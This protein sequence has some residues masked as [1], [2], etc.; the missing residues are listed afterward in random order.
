MYQRRCSTLS[1]GVLS[2]CAEKQRCV[3]LSSWESE[4]V[5][6]TIACTPSLGIQ[7]GL[8]ELGSK[9]VL[10]VASDSKCVIDHSRLRGHSVASKH[11][12]FR[13]LWL[14]EAFVDKKLA[15]EKVHTAER[16]C[17]TIIL[18]LPC[19]RIPVSQ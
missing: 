10:D 2:C 18:S 14:Q 7:S 16:A 17:Q 12:K 15:L 13:D 1:C 6:A 19:W 11:E 9:C 3:A 5:S 8:R 4:L